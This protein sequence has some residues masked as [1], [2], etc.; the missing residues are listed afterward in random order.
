MPPKPR[1]Q[2]RR[3][4]A[5]DEGVCGAHIEGC[6]CLLPSAR[7]AEVGHMIHRSFFKF[8]GSSRKADFNAD[9]NCQPECPQCNDRRRGQ[10]VDW[11][12]YK[13]QCHFLQVSRKGDKA[14]VEI[15]EITTGSKQVHVIGEPST[16]PA[17]RIPGRVVWSQPWGP[18]FGVSFR[19]TMLPPDGKGKG[20]S[21]PLGAG[22]RLSMIYFWQIPAFNWFERVRTGREMAGIRLKGRRGEDCIFMPDGSICPAE[23]CSFPCARA[24]DVRLGHKNRDINPFR[25][26]PGIGPNG[27]WSWLKAAG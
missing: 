11:P 26:P 6:G 17:R 20:F 24:F 15:H 2:L 4:M 5:R 12:L 23:R 7:D 21:L 10:L 9:W 3:I 16:D 25:Y 19:A 13:C 18:A 1:V 14:N 22:H 8:F 27:G